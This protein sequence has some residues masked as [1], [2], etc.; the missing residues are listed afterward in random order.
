MVDTAKP[1]PASVTMVQVVDG[2]WRALGNPRFKA[3]LEAW[4]AMTNDASLRAEI[5]P[6]VGGFASL[7]MPTGNSPLAKNDDERDFVFMARETMLGLALGRATNG[8]KALGHEKRVLARLRKEAA[9][10]DDAR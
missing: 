2:T 6:V 4:L 7:V 3:V 5:G 9:A 10:L 8:G 1:K